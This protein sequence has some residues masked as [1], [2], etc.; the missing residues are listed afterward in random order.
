[1]TTAAAA[2]QIVPSP[3]AA[4]PQLC[5]ALHGGPTGRCLAAARALIAAGADVNVA[6]GGS[7]CRVPLVCYLARSTVHTPDDDY[8]VAVLEAVLAHPRLDVHATTHR[9]ETALYCVLDE[10]SAM[11]DEGGPYGANLRAVRALIAA[12]AADGGGGGLGGEWESSEDGQSHSADELLMGHLA[13][14][15]KDLNTWTAVLADVAGSA[16]HADCATRTSPGRLPTHITEVVV[17]LVPRIVASVSSRSSGVAGSTAKEC[18]AR[19][20]GG[21][22]TAWGAAAWR[23]R[24]AALVAWWLTDEG[25][26]G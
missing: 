22:V 25:T 20:L 26:S 24:R 14:E 16:R 5:Y 7:G 2:C 10:A 4:A 23:R 1:M 11:A 9:G 8:R 6:Y 15:R 21:A 19:F 12:G 18:V 13:N 3:S 17:P